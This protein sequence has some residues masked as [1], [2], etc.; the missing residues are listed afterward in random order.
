MRLR[1]LDLDGGLA[2]LPPFRE[3]LGAG[4][5][6]RVDLRSW[7]ERLRLWAGRADLDRLRLTLAA[8]PPPP[9]TGLPVTFLGSGDYHHLSVALLDDA[10]ARAGLSPERRVTVVH[11][12]NHPDWVRRPPRGHCGS[13]VNRMLERATVRRVVTIG[14]CARDLSWPQWRGANLAAMA[15]GRIEL[16]P[17]RHEPSRVFGHAALRKGPGFRRKGTYIRWRN[18]GGAAW[19]G[20][21]PE[22]IASLPADDLLWITIDKDV[23][24][25]EDAATNWDQGEMPLDALVAALRR[26]AATGR[27]LG[28][29]VCGDYAPPC[30]RHP[31]KRLSAWLDQ[32]RQPPTDLARNARANIALIETF[33]EVV[34]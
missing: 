30:F 19:D 25:P 12:D 10:V 6:Q 11:F 22:M 26:L 20:F 18:V 15:S 32:P 16:Y 27:V 14:P 31:L 5:A 33:A 28:A 34:T 4:T 13:W 24:R 7:S 29:D 21:L 9:G 1:L 3:A 2:A 17:W 23:L 8:L